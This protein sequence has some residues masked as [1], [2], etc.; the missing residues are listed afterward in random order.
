M[1]NKLSIAK[2]ILQELKSDKRTLGLLVV[3]PII[4]LLLINVLF[5]SQYQEYN[6]GVYNETSIKLDIA[7]A[8]ISEFSNPN[9]L[10]IK[11]KDHELDY[12]L[13]IKKN[14]LDLTNFINIDNFSTNTK[15]VLEKIPDSE[16]K[17]VLNSSTQ[18]IPDITFIQNG[19]NPLFDSYI[20]SDI[21]NNINF[22][23]LT[24]TK[25]V[26]Y[27]F[28]SNDQIMLLIMEFICF[29]FAFITVGI[30]FLNERHNRTLQRMLCI[31]T[32]RLDIIFGYLIGYGFVGIVQTLIIE[33]MMLHILDISFSIYVIYS[34]LFNIFF[35][36]FGI[37]L[38][39]FIS[40][41]AKTEFQIMQFIPL[42][43]VPQLIFSA[44]LPYDGLYNIISK[45]LPLTYAYKAQENILLKNNPNIITSIIIIIIYITIFLIFTLIKLG[46]DKEL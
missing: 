38:G 6:L 29:F 42:I 32:S 14:K 7:N 18:Y 16:L 21:L 44:I 28:S 31:G 17:K 24:T 13:I 12:G 39:M 33:L 34:V 41:F 22:D 37:S 11:V 3:A 2:R 5:D 26:H 30:S 27:Q 40:S 4:L 15:Q 46:K 25:D 23:Q 45:I 35:T 10:E 20:K 36:F 43:I 9:N 8:N 1:S 19:N